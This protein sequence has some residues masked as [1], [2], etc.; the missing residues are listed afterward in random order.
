MNRILLFIATL[1][2]AFSAHAQPYFGVGA[3]QMSVLDQ[4]NAATTF[5]VGY[6]ANRFSI[7]AGT[8]NPGTVREK[9]QSTAS[10]FSSEEW[11]LNGFRV[12]ASMRMPLTAKFSARGSV[13]AYRL[14]SEFNGVAIHRFPD[15]GNPNNTLATVTTTSVETTHTVPGFGVGFEYALDRNASAYAEVERIELKAGMVTSERTHA[16]A[17]GA[18]IRIDF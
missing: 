13:T 18:G 8:F 7:E 14:K 4:S 1:T 3:S 15:P 2:V 9:E 16:T 17:I 11:K 10:D 6:G 12:S 5:F